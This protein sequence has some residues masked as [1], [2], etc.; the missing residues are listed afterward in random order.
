[1]VSCAYLNNNLV[2]RREFTECTNILLIA[3]AC[4]QVKG[5]AIMLGSQAR[6]PSDKVTEQ[7]Q[8]LHDHNCLLR[9]GQH[10]ESVSN[11]NRFLAFIPI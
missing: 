3:F 10:R 1:M 2:P 9:R 8:F 4:V 6:T 11:H 7:P 5:K